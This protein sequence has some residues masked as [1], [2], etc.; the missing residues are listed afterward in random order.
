MRN[1]SDGELMKLI[2][3]GNRQA[4]QE[5]YQRY[6]AIVFGY[7]ARLL[8]DRSTAEDIT[9]DVWMKAVRLASSY[10][11]EGSL[12]GWLLKITRHTALNF[13]RSQKNVV[14]QSGTDIETNQENGVPED[15]EKALLKNFEVNRIIGLIQELPDGQRVALLLWISERLSYDEIAS[16]MGLSESAV[17]SLIFRARRFLEERSGGRP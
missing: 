7:S 15:F 5:V 9:Q 3:G 13:F 10:R 17:K 12:K 11:G 1:L 2:S 14:L 8:K 16:E 6:G 4:F